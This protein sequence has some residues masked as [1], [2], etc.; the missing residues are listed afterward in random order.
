MPRQ[1]ISEH[2]FPILHTDASFMKI[3]QIPK[4]ETP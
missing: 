2:N 3:Y 1:N 4:A